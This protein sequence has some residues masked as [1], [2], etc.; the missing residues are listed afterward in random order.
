MQR[1]VYL[2]ASNGLHKIGSSADP[3]ARLAQ[4]ARGGRL[5]HCFLSHDSF[6]VESALHRR[7][8]ASKVDD[9]GREWFRLDPSDVDAICR[10]DFVNSAD[11]LP[12]ELH[13]AS[14]ENQKGQSKPPKNATTTKV[15][16]D[17]LRQAKI[18][19]AYDRVDLYDYL[20]SILRAPID[21]RYR[22]IV[23]DPDAAEG[24]E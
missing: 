5:L 2:I 6:Q 19:A 23:R 7:F 9:L 21:A 16:V 8:F 17:L 10:L 20:D 22:Q 12:E 13:P 3:V 4:I 14:L 1:Y 15:D 24:D 11:D 18:I